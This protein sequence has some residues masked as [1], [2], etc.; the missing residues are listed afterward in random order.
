MP[1]V[2]WPVVNSSGTGRRPA[3]LPPARSMAGSR[4]AFVAGLFLVCCGGASGE[5]LPFLDLPEE[6]IMDVNKACD[7]KLPL[8]FCD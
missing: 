5:K 3:A 1:G 7:Y 6:L 8:Q 2:V 4:I